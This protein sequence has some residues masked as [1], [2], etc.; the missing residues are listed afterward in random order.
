M[1]TIE[2]LDSRDPKSKEYNKL[3]QEELYKMRTLRNNHIIRYYD[4]FN[5]NVFDS[6]YFVVIS[7]FC[8]VEFLERFIAHK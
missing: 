3:A 8:Q 1:K 5:L 4:D 7:E 2:K 6:Y